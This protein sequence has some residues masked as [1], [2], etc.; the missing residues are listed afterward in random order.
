MDTDLNRLKEKIKQFNIE[1]DWDKFHNPKD[2]LVALMSEVGELADCYR[3][4]NKE[5]LDRIHTDPVKKKKIEEEI[6]D[7]MSYLIMIA[8]KTDID[9]F[10]AVEEKIEKNRE[11]YP[12][13]KMK[14]I[15][16]NPIEGF[17]GK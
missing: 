11:K 9:I 14:G 15:H 1:R 2:L 17:K 13:E 7:I 3:W 5:E 10:K 16:S 12:A 4:L 6:A 8:Y